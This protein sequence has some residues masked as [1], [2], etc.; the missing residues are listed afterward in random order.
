[1]LTIMVSCSNWPECGELDI[2][3]N[4]NALNQIWGTMH[5][6]KYFDG[7]CTETDGKGGSTV[8]TGTIPQGNFHKYTLEVDRSGTIESVRW[9]YDD[10]LYWQVTTDDLTADIWEQTIHTEYFILLNLAIGGAMP[11]NKSGKTTPTEATASTGT[12]T[13]DYVAV[14]NK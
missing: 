14:Y 5:C 1:M 2:M 10:A 3:E 9:F 6:D 11:N 12:M 13:V 4:V 8:P 7:Q